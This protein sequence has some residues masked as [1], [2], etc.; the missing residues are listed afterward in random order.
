MTTHTD[1]PSTPHRPLLLRV[2]EAGAQLSLS[3]G[4]I[5]KLIAT[6]DLRAVRIGRSVRIPAAAVDELIARAEST[7]TSVEPAA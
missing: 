1:A 6:G 4:M 2:E 7:P 5:Y 3:R